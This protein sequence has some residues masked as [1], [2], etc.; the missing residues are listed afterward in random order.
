MNGI[1]VEL[2]DLKYFLAVAEVENVNGAAKAFPISAG[3]LSKAVSKLEA[4]LDIR[5]FYRV[6]RGIKLTDH[7]EALKQYARSLLDLEEEYRFRL[8]GVKNRINLVITGPEVLLSQYSLLV[9]ERMKSLFVDHDLYV[10]F[11]HTDDHEVVHE[12][13]NGNAHIG[14][15]T[16]SALNDVIAKPLHEVTF[17]TCSGSSHP[18]AKLKGSK[19]P[20]EEVLKHAFVSPS[21]SILGNMST[22]Q[23]L[24]GWRDDKFPRIIS[25]H[26]TN[27]DLIGRILKSGIA[28][29]YLPEFYVRH[30]DLAILN[31]SGCPYVCKQR[32]SMICKRH[33]D[34]SW[35]GRLFD[36]F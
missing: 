32:I 7:G 33:K 10:D 8:S 17:K 24:D 23:S 5:L 16:H 2:T 12:V 35:L 34:L 27:L 20:V 6:G 11:R 13:A 19:I 28:V 29:A 36:S 26:A 21:R 31:V 30:L 18:L 4:E 22:S 9:I 1:L 15:S 3:S 25:Y 14:L